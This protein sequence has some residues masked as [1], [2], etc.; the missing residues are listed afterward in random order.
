MFKMKTSK[1][2]SAQLLTQS[3]GLVQLKLHMSTPLYSAHEQNYL[4]G[5]ATLMNQ[6][7]YATSIWK[8]A[9]IGTKQNKSIS[10]CYPH[11]LVLGKF[12][13]CLK[14]LVYCRGVGL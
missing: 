7:G 2:F 14:R 11:T 3:H 10:V 4:P 13:S 8:L 9:F 12:R 6:N 5:C 1:L